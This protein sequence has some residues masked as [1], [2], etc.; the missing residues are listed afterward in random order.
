MRAI[1]ASALLIAVALVVSAMRRPG[2]HRDDVAGLLDLALLLDRQRRRRRI[3]PPQ[4]GDRLMLGC[5]GIAT[6]RHAAIVMAQTAM[7]WKS[8]KYDL[9]A[10]LGGVTIDAGSA[11]E[12]GSR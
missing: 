4:A 1:A 12:N 11:S 8:C 5:E 6:D 3:N 9:T 7:H 10:A 2:G